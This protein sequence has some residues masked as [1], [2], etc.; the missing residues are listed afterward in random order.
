MKNVNYSLSV[1][2]T[3]TYTSAQFEQLTYK[4]ELKY[5]KVGRHK[6]NLQI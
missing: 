6:D 4:I 5:I 3:H 2:F 1:F